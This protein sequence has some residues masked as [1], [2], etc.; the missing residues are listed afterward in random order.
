MAQ[1]Q[2]LALHQDKLG[3]LWI[4]TNGGGI[5]I[6]NGREFKTLNKDNGLVDNVVFSIT[7]DNNG[8]IIIGTNGGLSIYNGWTF[9]NLTVDN[10]LPN[11]RVSKVIHD[12]GNTWIATSSGICILKNNKLELFKGT[13]EFNKASFNTVFPASK[14]SIWFGTKSKGAFLY[15]KSTFKN[16]TI[17]DSLISNRVND[18]FKDKNG[19]IW[20]VTDVGTSYFKNNKVFKYYNSSKNIQNGFQ[21][22]YSEDQI[23]CSTNGYLFNQSYPSDAI[24]ANIFFKNYNKY[25]FWTSYEDS[26]GNIWLGS[27]DGSG[28]FKFPKRTFFNFNST[29][30]SIFNNNVYSILEFEKNQ[31]YI[32]LFS[33]GANIV[34]QVA[35][36]KY[37]VSGISKLKFYGLNINSIIKLTNGDIWFGTGNGIT[38]YS[39]KN[40][41]YSYYTTPYQFKK[42][43]V[44]TTI[45]GKQVTSVEELINEAIY[46]LW[47]DKR[48][49]VWI[50]TKEGITTYINGKFENFSSKYPET[51]T[52]VYK[53][54]EDKNRNLWFCTNGG[55]FYYDYSKLIKLG[56]KD[57]FTDEKVVS[58]VQDKRGNFW[59]GTKQG[60]YRF[61][62]NF[63]I[64]IKKSNND[65]INKDKG[66]SSNNIYS[67]IIDDN[68][69]LF[70]GSDKGIDKFNLRKFN[71]SREIE[72][73]N[74][75]QLEGFM[76]QECNLNAC[77]KDSY[78]RL[79]FG[80]VGGVTVYDPRFD[81]K[82]NVKPITQIT[83][84]QLAYK[85]FDWTPYCEGFDSLTKLP[86][87]LI[88]PYDKNHITIDFVAASLAIPEKVRYQYVLKGLT[89]E[90]SPAKSKNEA[91]FPSLPDGEYTFLVKACNNDGVWNENPT[92]FKFK[93]LP[94]FWKTWWFY[95]IIALFIILL[96]FIYIKWRE[97]KLKKDKAI[98]ENTVRERTE[99]VVKQK[100]IVE[101]KNK[102]ITDS[103]NYAKNIQEALLVSTKEIQKHYEDSFVLFKPRD[104]VSGDFYWFNNK[105]NLNYIAAADCTGHGVP[106]AFMSMLGLAFLN[107]IVN[108][109]KNITPAEILNL[110]RENVIISL[111]QTGREG[112]S[113]DGMDISL[114]MINSDTNELT[115][116]GANNPLYLVRESSKFI[117]SDFSSNPKN[118]FISDDNSTLIETKA[119]KMPIGYYVKNNLFENNLYNLLE[120]DKIFLFSD[121]FADQFGG[122]DGKKFKYKRFKEIILDYNKMPMKNQ[123][124]SLE[125]EIIKWRGPI[126]QIDDII[127]I[128]IRF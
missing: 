14:D 48:G 67:L 84:L 106:G 47:E 61:D 12:F 13:D 27:Y 122:P 71:S 95:T 74:F 91:D 93:I 37:E 2:V 82:N 115:F 78:G 124:I 125:K 100:D 23:F 46:S 76:G 38:V 118:H 77:Y 24:T 32:G 117:E 69:N 15:T 40:D 79:W 119:D 28:L 18:I 5:S 111:H 107:E 94:P 45:I 75:G 63:F 4:G 29:E 62:D 73:E 26:E 6:Y 49:T 42:G 68:D 35:E 108:N 43:L 80:T 105:G 53:I 92:E 34:S 113:K 81:I 11:N 30:D 90:W 101:Q 99:E 121:G 114:C 65:L 39:P 60:L 59:F 58:M 97:A 41:K 126:E 116:A 19:K 56:E 9:K 20:F 17:N 36:G 112:E 85:E 87:N 3:N 127:V 128:G 55:V 89:E 96:L 25:K 21:S 10:G 98:L 33:K 103:I 64:K 120:G 44:G 86:I 72:I 83:S 66:L 51:K 52:V 50:A 31:Y 109:N 57:G 110:L 104:I 54:F 123:G 8:R 102:D 1:S 88:L 22:K 16:F 70:I 7:E